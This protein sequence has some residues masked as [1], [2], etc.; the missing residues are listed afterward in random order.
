VLALTNNTAG[1]NAHFAT[2]P[3]YEQELKLPDAHLVTTNYEILGG[4]ATALLVTTTD[5]FRVANPNVVRAFYDAMNLAVTTINTDKRA[6]AKL[7]LEL[8]NDRKNSVDDI[9]AMIGD[10]DYA[11]TLQPQKVMKTAEFM[12]KIG[13]IKQ[14]PQSIADLF[15][16]EMLPTGGD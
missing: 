11:F 8:A 7:Y 4:P 14:A 16:P 2:S 3:F 13:S 6:A 5:K 15:F 1:V 9:F 12:A 10:K